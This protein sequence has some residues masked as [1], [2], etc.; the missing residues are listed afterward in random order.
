MSDRN[1][2]SWIDP[3]KV[4]LGVFR[5]RTSFDKEKLEDLNRYKEE[6]KA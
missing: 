4:K 2:F 1:G 5:V 6:R 3:N